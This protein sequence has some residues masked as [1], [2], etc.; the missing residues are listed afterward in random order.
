MWPCS[1]FST[2]PCS[3]YVYWPIRVQLDARFDLA[4]CLLHVGLLV[5]CSCSTPRCNL[6]FASRARISTWISDL[7]LGGY[8]GKTCI[9]H[10]G[11]IPPS[12]IWSD[13]RPYGCDIWYVICSYLTVGLSYV[14]VL[15]H[16]VFYFPL[17]GL[18]SMYIQYPPLFVISWILFMQFA[19][20]WGFGICVWQIGMC[21]E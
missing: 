13:F 6:R 21:L 12:G 2:W 1:A 15:R 17:R 3:I 10:L 16:S 14:T 20:C 7:A 19:N 11:N 4:P 18:E 8:T 5:R 9:Q